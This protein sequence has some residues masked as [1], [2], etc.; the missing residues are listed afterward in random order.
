MTG[1]ASNQLR[2]AYVAEVTAGTTP[3]S[4]SF[5]TTDVPILMTATPSIYE[6]KTLIAGGARGGVGVS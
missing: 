3:S 4:P 2:S 1:S 6:S 5:K